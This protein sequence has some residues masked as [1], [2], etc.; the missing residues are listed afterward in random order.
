MSATPSKTTSI[1]LGEHHQTFAA[2][3]I[4]SGRYGSVSEVVRAG[5]RLLEEREMKLAALRA[6][7]EQGEKSPIA[8]GYSLERVLTRLGNTPR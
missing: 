4:S 7:L 6:A 8:E 3:Q 1:V 5:L 2:S